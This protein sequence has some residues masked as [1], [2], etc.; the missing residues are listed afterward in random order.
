LKNEVYQRKLGNSAP[1]LGPRP[2]NFEEAAS[3]RIQETKN[4]HMSPKV[5]V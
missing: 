1:E 5:G 3:I 2:V 4:E